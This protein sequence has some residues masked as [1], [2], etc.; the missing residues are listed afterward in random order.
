MGLV[1]AAGL[2]AVTVDA[3]GTLVQLVDPVPSL[4]AALAACG[5]ERE[6]EV[7]RAG[8]NA[9]ASYYAPRVH[10][11]YDAASLALL[12]RDCAGVFL[13]AIDAD[14]APEKFAP[15]YADALRFEPLPRVVETLERV[16]ALGLELAVV[17]NWDFS[18]HER[19]AEL[20]LA[21]YFAAV[22]HAARKPAPNG[23]LI[24]LAQ[25]GVAPA[26]ALHVGDNEVDEQAARAAGVAFAP[27]PLVDAVAALV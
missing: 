23:I 26:R 1:S 6:P 17:G 11:G 7:V 18:L 13:A 12:R 15:A 3:Y 4:V 20:R 2:D 21:R 14:L 10:E 22:V 5:V 9:E 19:L 27:A 25:M 8:F 16:R 24:A